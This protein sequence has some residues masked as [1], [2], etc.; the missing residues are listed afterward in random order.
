MATLFPSL[1]EKLFN[2][3]AKK[4]QDGAF[5]IRP[6][7]HFSPAPSLKYSVPIISDELVPVLEKGAVES[8][9]GIDRVVGP[10]E[11]QLTDGRRLEVDTI[12]FC[13]GYVT[14]FTVIEPQFDPMQKPPAAWTASSGS[15]GKPLPRLYRNIFPPQHSDSLAFMGCVAFSTAAFQLYDLASMAVAQVWKGTSAL[16]TP[17]EM[18]RAVDEHQAWVCASANRGPV[19]PGMV[20]PHEWMDWANDTAGTGVAEKLGWGWQGWKF[21]LTEP[22]L[23]S[24]LMSGVYSPHIYR[25]FDGKRKKWPDAREEIERVN[26]RLRAKPK[27]A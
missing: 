16:P 8:V 5:N 22:K 1:T 26:E 23:C 20:K 21:W 3:F 11:V 15:R 10:R 9:A 18:E 2:A 6:E 13:T 17:A 19:F 7:W 4:L 12:I 25:L 14:K 27:T 24:L